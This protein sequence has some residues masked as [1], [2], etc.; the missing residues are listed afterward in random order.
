MSPSSSRRRAALGCALA[1]PIL[2]SCADDERSAFDPNADR[3]PPQLVS[4]ELVNE[5]QQAY[6]T[7]TANE[8]VR[9]VV[10]SGDAPDALW[11]HSYSGTKQ[12]DTSGVVKLVG[13]PSNGS[14]HFRVRLRDRAGNEASRV[15]DAAAPLPAGTIAAE[16]LLYFAMIDVGWGDALLLRAPDGT[17]TLVDAGHPADGLAVRQ[18]LTANGVTSLDFASLSHIHEDPI[19]GFY[20]DEFLDLDGLFRTF[21]GVQA[22]PCGTFIDIRDKTTSN[23]PYGELSESLDAHPALG[24]V[25]ELRWGASSADGEPALQWGEGVRV[26][27]LS[28]GRKAY[29]DPE[30]ILEAE[31]GSVVNND[32]MVY[33][34]QF[35]SFVRLLMGDGEFTTEQFLQD[36]WPEEVLGATVLKVGHH[37]SNDSSSERFVRL[38]N[39]LVA[40]ISNALSENP[41]V[42]TATTLGRYRN[43]GADYFASDRAIPN[44]ARNLPGVRADVKIWTDGEGFTVLAVPTRF[45]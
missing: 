36:R 19:G 1:L 27:L 34:V 32:S 33:R 35:G 21:T 2:A 9:A 43:A 14:F 3:D 45:E 15:P 17:T 39:P 16:E 24:Q 22:I 20:G 4:F 31:N 26:D 13:L 5:G 30:F 38:V 37:G 40:L 28:A 29:L 23:G 6:V 7:W 44:R 10:E 12:Y 41:G 18:F 8:P 11:R 42:E 25:V